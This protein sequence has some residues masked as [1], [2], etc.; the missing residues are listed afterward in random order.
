[1]L[2]AAALIL[3]NSPLH[4]LYDPILTAQAAIQIGALATVLFVMPAFAFANA[5]VA[6]GGL[7]LADLLSGIGFT[8]S[9]FIGTMEFSDPAHATAVRF[10][11]L[12]GST[13]SALAGYLALRFHLSTP[14]ALAAAPHPAAKAT[15]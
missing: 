13:L 3:G 11:V 1:M 10:G 14:H 15:N 4:R 8:V 6:L 9:L 7:S 12:S 2:A 5:G